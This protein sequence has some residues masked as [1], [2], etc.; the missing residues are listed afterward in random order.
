MRQGYRVLGTVIIICGLVLASIP[1]ARW[2]VSFYHQY[3]ALA[4]WER[5]MPVLEPPENGEEPEQPKEPLPPEP[6]VKD[7]LPEGKA[8]IHIPRL[9]VTAVIV[10]GVSEDDL[11]RGPGFYPQSGHPET[12]NV[13]IASHRG[14]YG[15]YF[16]YLNRLD[17]GDEI[18]VFIGDTIYRYEMR[19]RFITHSR[20]WGVVAQAGIPEL[21][22]TTC[23]WNDLSRRMIVKADLVDVIRMVREE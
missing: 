8:V 16:R 20:D 1:L 19:E 7:T 12:G 3:R 2:G 17:P 13:S 15:S 14:T 18:A 10:R 5:E 23:V 6:V 21:T 22:L 9:K 11:K 4:A